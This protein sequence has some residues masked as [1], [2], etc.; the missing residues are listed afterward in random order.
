M[1][2]IV[3][4]SVL[5]NSEVITATLTSGSEQ[6]TAA[7]NVAARG[8]AGTSADNVWGTITGSLAA[9][10]DLQTALNLKAPLAGPT[11]TGTVTLPSTTSIGNVSATEIGYIDGVTS[12]IQ[13]QLNAK[14]PLVSPTFTGIVTAPHIEGKATGT[15]LYC[16]AGQSI[17]AGQVVYVTGASGQNII[18]GLAQADTEPTSSKTIGVCQD[19][20]ANNAFGYVVTEGIMTVSISAPSAAEGDPIWLSPT[21]AGGMVFGLANKPSAPNHIVYLGVVTRKTGSTVV[22]ILVKVQNGVE[23]DEL[24][25]V[26]ITNAVSGQALMRGATLWTNRNL[27]IADITDATTYVPFL[28]AASNTFTGIASFTSTTRPTSSGTG[29]P[30]ATSLITRDDFYTEQLFSRPL[31][32]TYPMYGLVQASGG[33]GLTTDFQTLQCVATN[34]STSYGLFSRTWTHAPGGTG[35]NNLVNQ[36][37][38]FSHTGVIDI[39]NA[40]CAVRFL[41]GVATGSAPNSDANALTGRGVGWEVYYSATNSRNEIRILTHNGTT[42]TAGTGVAFPCANARFSHIVLEI[43]GTGT[44]NLYGSNSAADNGSSGVCPRPSSTPIATSAVGPSGANRYSGAFCTLSCVTTTT[45]TA[46]VSMIKLQ[47]SMIKFS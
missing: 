35:Q 6:M 37:V 23:L 39:S 16:K 44:V 1:A 43:L 10:T 36:A 25:D 47:D 22:E 12:A 21:T 17:G 45:G 33:P 38:M 11:F 42:Y 40:F 24:S 9:Q 14:A 13:T 34:G 3:T 32:R 31:A 29:A 8:P 5:A 15:E 30:A 7:I 4:A 41:V 27:V 19:A 46:G 28:A 18:I 20:L 26:A 2:E